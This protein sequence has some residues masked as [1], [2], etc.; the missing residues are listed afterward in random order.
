MTPLFACFSRKGLESILPHRG[1]AL[2]KIDGAFYRFSDPGVM[3]GVKEIHTDDP[4]LE[5]HFPGAPTYPGYA[6]DEFICLAAA[7]LVSVTNNGLKTNPHVVQKTV[8]YKRNAGPGDTLISEVK[9]TGRRGRFI[10][11]SGT[12]KNQKQE[13]VAEYERIVGAI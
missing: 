3:T 1:A 10:L 5:G 7:V 13:I 2:G 6:Q 8:R 11:F 9:L 12:I 4:D